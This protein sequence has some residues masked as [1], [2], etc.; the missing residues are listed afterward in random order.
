MLFA[1]L[2]TRCTHMN[3]TCRMCSSEAFRSHL[4][5]AHACTRILL[6]GQV[7]ARNAQDLHIL[8]GTKVAVQ[9]VLSVAVTGRARSKRRQMIRAALRTN[10]DDGPV[11]IVSDNEGR[12]HVPNSKYVATG[13]LYTHYQVYAHTAAHTAAHTVT[14]CMAGGGGRSHRQRPGRAVGGRDELVNGCRCG[15]AIG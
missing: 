10:R 7:H 5:S 12:V 2:R 4:G 9:N 3:A 15:D 6:H 13:T 11:L 8:D 1:T 14:R